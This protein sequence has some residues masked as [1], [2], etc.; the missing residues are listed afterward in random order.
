MYPRSGLGREAVARVQPDSRGLPW[1]VTRGGNGHGEGPVDA[2][3][4]PSSQIDCRIVVDT[5]DGCVCKRSRTC[6]QSNGRFGWEL[7]EQAGH[8]Q[9]NAASTAS[10]TDHEPADRVLVLLQAGLDGQSGSGDE[11]HRLLQS[12]VSDELENENWVRQIQVLYVHLKT[13]GRIGQ[14]PRVRSLDTHLRL[15]KWRS[16]LEVNHDTDDRLSRGGPCGYPA[17]GRAR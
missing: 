14:R 12:A 16:G 2:K 13:T 11:L 3:V 10:A 15:L 5:G 9:A 8:D 6:Y 17:D 4:F 1:R 7:T